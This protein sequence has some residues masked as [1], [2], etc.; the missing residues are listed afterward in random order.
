MIYLIVYLVRRCNFAREVGEL[1]LMS[2][3]WNEAK[4]KK[5]IDN[6]KNATKT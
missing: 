3:Y 2:D 1:A 6:T 5:Q 4:F